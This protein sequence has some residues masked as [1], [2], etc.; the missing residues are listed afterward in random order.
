MP[1]WMRGFHFLPIQ[2]GDEVLVLVKDA[3]LVGK[4]DE[5]L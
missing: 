4:Q 5:L 1:E 2:R 3:R